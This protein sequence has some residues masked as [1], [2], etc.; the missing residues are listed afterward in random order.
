MEVRR[1]IALTRISWISVVLSSCE[2]NK[3]A[4]PSEELA[5]KGGRAASHLESEEK[6]HDVIQGECSATRTA[7]EANA[8]CIG[9]GGTKQALRGAPPRKEI[10]NELQL[11]LANQR[12]ARNQTKVSIL[13]NKPGAKLKRPRINAFEVPHSGCQRGARKLRTVWIRRVHSRIVS[14]QR[15][16]E[17]QPAQENLTEFLA[18]KCMTELARQERAKHC[19]SFLPDP[20]SAIPSGRAVFHMQQSTSCRCD[21]VPTPFRYRQ[22]GRSWQREVRGIR[23]RAGAPR[24]HSPVRP[25]PCSPGPSE[26]Q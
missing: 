13:Q 3:A 1:A 17:Q 12:K 15:T 20:R 5:P 21:S 26:A 16:G 6:E 11:T 14:A 19:S 23:T 24:A 4:D 7:E 25:C 9:N 22:G 2:A 18:Q 8:A 10:V